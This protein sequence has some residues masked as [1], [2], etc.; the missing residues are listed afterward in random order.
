MSVSGGG[1]A[2]RKKGAWKSNAGCQR[3][4]RKRSGVQRRRK[5]PTLPQDSLICSVKPSF[6]PSY[7]RSFSLMN[8]PSPDGNNL[9]K[10]IFLTVLCAL[11]STKGLIVLGCNL[12]RG[13]EHFC[14]HVNRGSSC[15][16]NTGSRSIRWWDPALTADPY[17]L[18]GPNVTQC[19]L[20]YLLDCDRCRTLA[21]TLTKQ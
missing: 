14:S 1:E 13:S 6:L 7:L 4:I 18:A 16:E 21:Q 17:C 11:S 19:A 2:E 20:M 9:N 10:I 3:W 5:V 15:C 12:R 8:D